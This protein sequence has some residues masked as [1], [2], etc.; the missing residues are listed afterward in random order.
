M[1]CLQFLD[2]RL[3]W[4]VFWSEIPKI[5]SERL[6]RLS[7]E[8]N[9]NGRESSGRLKKILELHAKHLSVFIAFGDFDGDISWLAKME[10]NS[11][12]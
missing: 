12:S 10:S 2:L 7:L 1:P 9:N 11:I 5:S 4:V 8:W 3:N 6:L